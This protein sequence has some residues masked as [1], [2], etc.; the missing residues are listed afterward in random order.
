MHSGH[1][2]QRDDCI[3][4]HN[5]LFLTICLPRYLGEGRQDLVNSIDVRL[6]TSS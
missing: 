3:K 2:I 1:I 6:G 5:S 4:V